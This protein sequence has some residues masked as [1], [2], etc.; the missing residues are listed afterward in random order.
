LRT[1]L[2]LLGIAIGIFA[3][4]SVYAIVDS[5]ERNIRTSVDSIGT[6]VVFVQ[7]WPWAA[8][9]DS[10]PWWKYYQR[11][12]VSLKDYKKLVNRGI[13]G[14]QYMSFGAAVRETLKYGNSNIENANIEGVTFEAG[15]IF[16]PKGDGQMKAGRYFSEKENRLG[17]SVCI[18]GSDICSGLFGNKDPIGRSITAF[19]R[20]FN[21]IGVWPKQGNSLIGQSNDSKMY[22]PASL[23]ISMR[24]D[25]L[26]QTAIHFKAKKYIPI[27]TF[28]DEVRANMRAIRRLSPR[29]EDD[30]SINESSIISG[31]LDT[32]FS[33]IGIAGTIIGGFSILVGGF[34]IANIMFVSVRER[35]G[36]IGI[37]KALGAKNSFILLQFLVE[38]TMLSVLGGI[39]GILF[40]SILISIASFYSEF[41]LAMSLENVFTGIGLSAL[42]GL[43][44]GVAPASMAAKL[45]PVD[46]IRFNQ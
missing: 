35:T 39:L 13:V 5:L 40:V 21:V 46:A 37:Q 7:K 4:I 1:C 20:Q 12:E 6:D 25:R 9:D 32:M 23:L 30:F 45:D 17:K 26:S 29:A 38:S 43:V 36:Q 18:I 42:I 3:I 2:S 11:P 10:Y 15:L 19:G 34:G 44:S 41:E 33:A 31:G 22:I 16:F 14:S 8:G 28:K 27:E 24:G